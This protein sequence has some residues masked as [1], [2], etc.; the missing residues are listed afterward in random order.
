M[1][2]VATIVAAQNATTVIGVATNM[3]IRHLTFAR[4]LIDFENCVHINPLG[5]CHLQGYS[6]WFLMPN[7]QPNCSSQK[8]SLGQLVFIEN[9]PI[10]AVFT[11]THKLP[12]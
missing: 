5:K 1:I 4:N 2:G 11:S 8:A 6:S 10:G 9:Q 3:F 7:E 12:H